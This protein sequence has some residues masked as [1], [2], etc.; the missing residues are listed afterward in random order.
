MEASL[1]AL[2]ES[3]ATRSSEDLRRIVESAPGEYTPNAVLV[4]QEVL[5]SRPAAAAPAET[6]REPVSATQLSW[7]SITAALVAFYGAKQLFYLWLAAEKNPGA[8]SREVS[9]ALGS[10]WTY[11]LVVA[12]VGVWLWGRRGRAT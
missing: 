2:R 1:D 9:R 5:A 12:L 10:P 4:A 3:Y 6:D 7:G 8:L 11:V